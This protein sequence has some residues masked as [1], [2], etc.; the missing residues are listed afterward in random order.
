MFFHFF[1]LG[2]G[3]WESG[4]TG[5]A[6]GAQFFLLKI[7]GRVGGLPGGLEEGKD[8]HPQDKI[9]HLDFTY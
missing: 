5:T 4:A 8:P 2:E 6:G 7:P 1:G 9:Q 3:K